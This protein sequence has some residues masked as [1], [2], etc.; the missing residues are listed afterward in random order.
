MP[1]VMIDLN[2]GDN[3][4]FRVYVKNPDLDIVN[5]T[6]ALCLFTVKTDKA[7]SAITFQKSTAYPDQGE[8]GS[9]DQ[10][11]VFFYIVPEDTESL[12]IRQYVFDIRVTLASGKTY[13]VL[14]GVI[15]LQKSVG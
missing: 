1:F 4:T 5:L 9:P 6:G 15:D 8:I 2:T 10:G 14:D 7:T 3:R 12:A 11:E 13:T